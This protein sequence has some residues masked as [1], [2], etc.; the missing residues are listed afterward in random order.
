MPPKT[1]ISKAM[2][3]DAGI[4]FVRANGPDKITAQAIAKQLHCSTQPIMYHFKK[5]EDLRKAIIAKADAYH[6]AYLMNIQGENV[7]MEIGLNYITFAKEEP[8]LFRL[9]FQSNNFAKKTLQNE[10]DSDA[11]VNLLEI[12]SKEA[13][14]TMSQAK[15]VFKAL[16]LVVH[17]YASMFANNALEDHEDTIRKD[18]EFI[19]EGM[20]NKLKEEP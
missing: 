20:M 19:Y 9:L 13:N 2:I 15:R 5:V 14:I 10:F 1:K 16:F 6:S 3:E 4:V 18:L 7:M 12:F 8:N 17:G 11:L